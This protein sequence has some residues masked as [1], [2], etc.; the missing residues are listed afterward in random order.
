MSTFS[1][2]D[3]TTFPK[4]LF[5]ARIADD[6]QDVVARLEVAALLQEALVAQLLAVVGGDDDAGVLP[7]AE[8]PQAVED[9]AQLLVD[10]GDH[11]V[12]LGRD[13][14]HLV[15]V[16]GGRDCRHPSAEGDVVARR[17]RGRHVGGVIGARPVAGR[18]VG[19]VRAQV[20]GVREPG[21]LLAVQP[22]EQVVREEGRD[23]VLGRA[24]RL[25]GQQQVGVLRQVR[26]AE[27]LQPAAPGRHVVEQL[28]PVGE[29]VREPLPVEE[30]GVVGPERG[31]RV[32]G[33]VGVPEDGRRVAGPGRSQPHV[34][35]ASVEGGA[36]AHHA[37]GHLVGAGQEAGAPGRAGRGLAVVA[38]QAH[39]GG[40]Q[41]VEVGRAHERVAGDREAVRPEL[42]EGDEQH[43]HGVRLAPVAPL[44]CTGRSSRANTPVGAAAP[45][46]SAGM[47]LMPAALAGCRP[48]SGPG[49]VRPTCGGSAPGRPAAGGRPRWRP[50]ARRTHRSANRPR[51]VP[52][53]RRR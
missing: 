1:V 25:A 51:S 48:L 22:A 19:R 24:L 4:R 18:G 11:P 28:E 29:A 23:A 20:A 40:R 44:G 17:H 35:E 46:P 10:V 31:R 8:A 7:H 42:V 41:G 14:A 37:V 53:P 32:E 39:P 16:G 38:G 2:N 9:P 47:L 34:V 33:L 30:P 50:P 15:L 27:L 5:V 45:R 36:I 43:V 21:A 13:L 49:P 12:V 26:V 6:A 52:C 3:S